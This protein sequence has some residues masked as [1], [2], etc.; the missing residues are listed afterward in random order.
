MAEIGIDSSMV[1]VSTAENFKAFREDVKGAEYEDLRS[2]SN[3]E[4]K[5]KVMNREL[6]DSLEF[7]FKN[8][9]YVSLRVITRND[10]EKEYDNELTNRKLARSI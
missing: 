8:H 4:L 7:L 1:K 6:S 10:Y 5:K 2:F 9:R 3:K